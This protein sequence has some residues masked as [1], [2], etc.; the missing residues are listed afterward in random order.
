[1]L[2]SNKLIFNGTYSTDAIIIIIIIIPIPVLELKLVILTQT[3]WFT[4]E[5]QR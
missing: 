1:L 5:A 3:V 2:L 4:K